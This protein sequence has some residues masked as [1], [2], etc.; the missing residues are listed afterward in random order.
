[1]VQ[2]ALTTMILDAI[3][4]YPQGV[5]TAGGESHGLIFGNIVAGVMEC[6]YVFPVGNVTERKP[7]E[8]WNNPKVDEA[9]KNAKHI[10]FTSRCCGDYHSH[11]YK[12]FFEGAA[13]PSNGDLSYASWLKQLY[14]MIIAIS[15][16]AILEKKLAG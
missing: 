4:F 5:R 8:I 3:Q 16:K 9:I 11:P 14:M 1:M 6:D 12:L 2:H 13:N 7:D 15:R 10:L